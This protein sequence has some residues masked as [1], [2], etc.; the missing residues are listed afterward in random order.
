MAAIFPDNPIHNWH[1]SPI[2]PQYP[3]STTK[4]LSGHQSRLRHSSVASGGKFTC[5]WD[6][7]GVAELQILKNFYREVGSWD[8]FVFSLQFWGG[9]VPQGSI[10]YY[11]E[12]SPTGFWMI[13]DFKVDNIVPTDNSFSAVIV[14]AGVID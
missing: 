11:Q 14:F 1:D 2:E 13:E 5:Y 3:V 12:L 9:C 8:S 7:I 6:S 4:M 10:N